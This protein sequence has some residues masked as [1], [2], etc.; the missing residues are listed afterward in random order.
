MNCVFVSSLLFTPQVAPLFFSP[1]DY[2]FFLDCRVTASFP[3]A[4][5]FGFRFFSFLQTLLFDARISFG[6]SSLLL[7][8]R[9]RLS[10]FGTVPTWTAV[11]SMHECA[12]PPPLR[13]STFPPLYSS[14]FL[15]SYPFSPFRLAAGGGFS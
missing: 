6:I 13:A 10:P 9:A 1:G 7:F 15:R 2:L 12:S 4:A 3:G 5:S 11:H 14:S 8:F